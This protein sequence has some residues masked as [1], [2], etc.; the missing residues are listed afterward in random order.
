MNPCAIGIRILSVALVAASLLSLLGKSWVER[1]V[2]SKSSSTLVA[3]D[4][5]GRVLKTLP[6]SLGSNDDGPKLHEGDRRTPE[7]EYVVCFKNPQSRFHRSLALSYPNRRDADRALAE[8]RIGAEDHR[9]ILEAQVLR[10][11]PPWKTPL[12]GEIFIHGGRESHAATA[13]C[14]AIDSE[15][16]DEL[17][18]L[19][20]MGTPVIIEP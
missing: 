4:S 11:I 18:P 8:G 2:V 5:G 13:G 10:R 9:R 1:I 17:Y 16:I 12:G 14:I 3:Y 20:A 19:V 15:A 7:G 6:V